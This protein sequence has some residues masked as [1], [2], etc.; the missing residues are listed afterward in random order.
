M[1]ANSLEPYPG[2]RPF[3]KDESDIFFGRDDHIGEMIAKLSESHFLCVTG[4]SGCGKSS[5]ARTG[6][7]N[8]LEAGFLPGRGSD[9]IF[10][11]LNPGDHPV[12]TLFRRIADAIVE[13]QSDDGDALPND[14]PDPRVS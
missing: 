12:D 10:C 3:R 11:D 2:L 13:V 9:W 4:S 6:L 7:M 1:Y 8:H 14:P 5:L